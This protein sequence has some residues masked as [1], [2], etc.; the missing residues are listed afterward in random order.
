MG[1][2][3]IIAGKSR[4][5]E[6]IDLARTFSPF[7]VGSSVRNTMR[8]VARIT[9][10]ALAQCVICANRHLAVEVKAVGPQGS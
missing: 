1:T 6:W 3:R 9:S 10:Q 8:A 5:E 2:S 7:L 4:K